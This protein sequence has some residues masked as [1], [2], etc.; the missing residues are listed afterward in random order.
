M[1]YATSLE[2][3]TLVDGL[4]LVALR[5]TFGGSSCPNLWS[6]ISESMTDIANSLL[7]NE[8]WDHNTLYNSLSNDL[9]DP[10]SLDD[11]VP[12][13]PAKTY[14]LLYRTIYW[15]MQISILM[16]PLGLHL[17]WG[18]TQNASPGRSH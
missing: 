15:G 9:E 18:T 7:H 16:T 8:F 1:S 6:V 3:L 4:L 14:P 12:F 2:S 11:N 13:H 17:I 10:L 5:L